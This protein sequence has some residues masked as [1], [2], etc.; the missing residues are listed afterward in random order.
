VLAITDSVSGKLFIYPNPNSGQFQVRYYS[1]LNNT[2]LP[3]GINVFD[4]RGKRVL[5]KS[6]SIT[7]PYARMDVNLTNLSTGIY[8]VEVVDGEGNRLAIGRAEVLR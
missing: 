4:A 2:G 7:A 1:A 3:R 5:T 8:W 6:Y